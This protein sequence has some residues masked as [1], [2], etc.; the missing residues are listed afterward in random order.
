MLIAKHE[1]S[2]KLM[3]NSW[4]KI[5]TSKFCYSSLKYEGLV[6]IDPLPQLN[7]F[8]SKYID[9]S[10][11]NQELNN[12][13]NSKKNYLQKVSKL[14]MLDT[15]KGFLEYKSQMKLVIKTIND[16][17]CDASLE[18]DDNLKDIIDY[19]FKMS[20]KMIRPHFIIQLSKFIYECESK[21]KPKQE[22]FE[23][24]IFKEKIIPYAACIEAMHNASLLQDDIIDNSHI[25]RSKL[26]AHNV[27]GVR[28]TIF[29]SNY[30]LS[31]AADA[32]AN[33]GIQELNE[34]YSNIVYDLTY[35][36][37]QQ[38]IKRPFKYSNSKVDVL[39]NMEA[40]ITKTY[41]KTASLIALSFRGIAIIFD[42]DLEKQKV[43]FNLGLHLGILFQLVDDIFDVEGDSVTLKKPQYKDIKE[44]VVNS[45][46]IFETMSPNSKEI[47][48]M[49]KRKFTGD[50]DFEKI[51]SFL[52][53]GTGILKTKNLALDHLLETIKL[54]DDPYFVDSEL[55]NQLKQGIIYMFNRTY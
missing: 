21:G 31:R 2:K 25:R 27:Y 33:I 9:E 37:Y 1:M 41:Y 49:I 24:Q 8:M 54:F 19:Y 14:G 55:Q 40:Y 43:F 12:R 44:G 50:N 18:E 28:N 17:I 15:F 48:E 23:T 42:L 7:K 11:D 51:L 10:L 32:I 5:G 46:L 4:L 35:G 52:E 45:H 16:N 26:T 20:G 29:A 47:F 39:Y 38:T 13:L 22:F 36:E 3:F 6:Q 34:V 30:I 53:S